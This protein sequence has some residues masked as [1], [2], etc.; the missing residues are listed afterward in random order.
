[1]REQAASAAGGGRGVVLSP[2]PQ[3]AL[4]SP[5]SAHRLSTLRVTQII[6]NYKKAKLRLSYLEKDSWSLALCSSALS[7]RATPLRHPPSPAHRLLVVSESGR[8]EWAFS[9]VQ[10]PRC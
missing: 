9:N 8:H 5:A 1:M 3:L 6:V 7:A 4:G 10:S 2:L